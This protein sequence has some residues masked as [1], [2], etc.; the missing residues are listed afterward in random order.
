M[1][2]SAAIPFAIP[3]NKD[4][5]TKLYESAGGA[6]WRVKGHWPHGSPCR[7]HGIECENGVVTSIDL[8]GNGATGTLPS[9]L[10]ALTRL[11]VLNI[12]ESRLSGTLPDCHTRL[13][14]I[15]LATNPNLSGTL[16]SLTRLTTLEELDLS[17]TR[18]S[19]TIS[20]ALGH[21]AE[22]QRLQLDHTVITG[23][24][25]TQVGRLRSVESLFLHE[26][27]W[28]SGTLPTELGQLAPSLRLGMSLA[29]T[30][31]SGTIPTHITHLAKL[32]AL[33]LVHTRLSGTLPRSIGKMHLAE[34]EVHASRLSGT[35]PS[36]LGELR[37][38]LRRCVLIA[39][40]GP[41]QT[42]HSMRPADRVQPDTNH[43]DCPLPAELPPA[44]T[45]HL[46]CTPALTSLGTTMRSHGGRGAER[47][48]GRRGRGRGRARLLE[49]RLAE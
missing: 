19:G 17:R 1:L 14:T 41:H 35:L 7:W 10:C 32:R 38:S 8:G 36:E 43:F 15:L 22:L 33:W 13:R 27:P 48:D 39:A 24:V 9:E 42:F 21:L 3:S 40:Q 34:L 26:S 31:L 29:S 23:T 30:R 12:D 6:K 46:A 11:R 47:R 18:I 28:L 16:P 2:A 49:R 4:A 20:T 25:P 37:P 45:Q 44:C 5:L